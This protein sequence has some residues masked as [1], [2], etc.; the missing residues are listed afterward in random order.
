M[1]LQLLRKLRSTHSTISGFDTLYEFIFHLRKDN[2]DYSNLLE[3]VYDDDWNKF[4][5]TATEYKRKFAESFDASIQ[6]TRSTRNRDRDANTI[7][8]LDIRF[9]DA[10]QDI[11]NDFYSCDDCR[12]ITHTDYAT[13]IESEDIYVCE[14]CRDRSYLFHENDQ[15]Y[16]HQDSYPNDDDDYYEDDEDDEA[17]YFESHGYYPYDTNPL[18]YLQPISYKKEK[19]QIGLE[20]EVERSTNCPSDITYKIS[21][22]MRNFAILKHDGSLHDGFEIVTAPAT[23]TIQKQRWAEFCEKNYARF[24][25]SWNTTTCGMHIHVSRKSVTPLDIG[26]LL[27][28]VNGT[29]NREFMEK[30]AGRSSAQWSAFK[31]KNVKDGLQRSDKYEAL[32]THKR[33]TIEFRLFRGNIAKQGIFRNLEFVDALCEFVSTVSIDRASDRINNLSYTNFISYM[34]RSE[35]KGSYPY[36]FSWLVRKGYNKGRTKNIQNESEES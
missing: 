19:R 9:L 21:D 18:D 27:V 36:L 2:W 3:Q 17:S 1:T 23:M 35:N 33:N 28:F 25:K 13:Y 11:H 14:S 24:L 26:K 15:M 31:H 10:I 16:Y 30:I 20:A 7:T 32:A 4:Y 34:N 5:E 8:C 29:A 6:A 22:T 12:S